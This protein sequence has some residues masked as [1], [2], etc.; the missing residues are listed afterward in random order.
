MTS[1]LVHD[2]A[3]DSSALGFVAGTAGREAALQQYESY[4]CRLNPWMTRA[5]IMPVGHG[6]VGEQLVSRAAFEN[7]EYYYDYLHN[8]GLES[9]FGLA[10]FKEK[11]QYFVLNTLTGDKDLDRNR[12]RAAQLTAV[13][14]WSASGLDGI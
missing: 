2:R 1:M 3:D 9:G 11:S 5:E 10:L 13:Y 7:S 8:E 4:Y 14:R 6:I 12:D